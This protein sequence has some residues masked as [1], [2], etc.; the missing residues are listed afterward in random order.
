MPMTVE[1]FNTGTTPPGFE[2][3]HNWRPHFKDMVAK[4]D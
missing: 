1:V 2:R 3:F 4:P